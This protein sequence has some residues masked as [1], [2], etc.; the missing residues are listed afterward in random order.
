M[1]LIMYCV[2]CGRKGLYFLQYRWTGT[3]MCLSC[4]SALIEH[5]LQSIHGASYISH[6]DLKTGTFTLREYPV[7]IKFTWYQCLAHKL[8]LI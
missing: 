6:Y 7:K 2:I 5:K 3:N 4:A 8:H 1:P